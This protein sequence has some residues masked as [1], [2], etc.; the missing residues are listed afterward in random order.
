M[1][2]EES[3]NLSGK[4]WGPI[5]KV[6]SKIPFGYEV[7]EDNP[8]VLNPIIFELEALERAKVYR[9]RGYS[10]RAL[11]NWV[12]HITGRNITSEGLRQRFASDR[13]KS[14][15]AQALAKWA[16]K[17]R[18]ALAQ[19]H[20][21]DKQLGRDTEKDYEKAVNELLKALTTSD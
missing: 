18:E 17:Y 2:A 9:S 13:H 7:S 10:L 14:G 8:L 4:T 19:A 6:T 12:S 5:P 15:K 11:A 3:I 16:R 20:S 21:L 1:L